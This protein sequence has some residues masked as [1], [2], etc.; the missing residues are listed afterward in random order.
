MN[1]QS[2]CGWKT[3]KEKL[4]TFHDNCSKDIR[5]MPVLIDNLKTVS[6]MMVHCH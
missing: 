6:E 4:L 2:F 5:S 3:S 1:Q